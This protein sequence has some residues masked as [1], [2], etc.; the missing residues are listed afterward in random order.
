[1]EVEGLGPVGRVSGLERHQLVYL[2][3]RMGEVVQAQQVVGLT[4][5]H[6]RVDG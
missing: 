2:G 1:M 6:E 4:Q 5:G 3:R